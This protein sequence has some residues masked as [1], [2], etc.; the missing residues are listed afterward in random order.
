MHIALLLHGPMHTFCLYRPRC[1]HYHELLNCVG[2]GHTV[3]IFY[4][5]DYEDEDRVAVFVENYK[6]VKYVNERI[7][8]PNI[9]SAYPGRLPGTDNES[10]YTLGCQLI[11]KFRVHMLLEEHIKATNITYD[12]VI[13]MRLDLRINTIFA[14]SN[15][16]LNE[17]SIYI[18]SE[19]DCENGVNDQFAIGSMKVMKKY[20][21]TYKYL[22]YLLE[23]KLS[24]PHAENLN[25]ANLKY[26]EVVIQRFP[27]S[28]YIIKEE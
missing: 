14:L 15:S 9:L 3:D 24:I 5:S 21:E 27:F 1:G 13:C 16:I 8:H 18:P 7:I 2:R 6:P 23:N 19:G 26:N 11:N 22:Q 10:L 20:C 25:L 12:A 4:S 28:Y 17:N